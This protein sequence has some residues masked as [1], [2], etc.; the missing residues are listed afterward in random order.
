MIR[1]LLTIVV[2]PD[3]EEDVVDFLLAADGVGGF[4]SLRASGHGGAALYRSVAEQ[5]AGRVA[6]IEFQVLLEE[7]AV[8]AIERAL[9]DN[10][11]GSH[12]MYW[13]SPVARSG[14]LTSG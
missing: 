10:F 6:R 8:D 2:S 1:T 4:T 13:T 11:T 14:H 5:V 9:I 12:L 3:L 7:G